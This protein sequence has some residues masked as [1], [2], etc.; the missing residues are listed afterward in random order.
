MTGASDEVWCGERCSVLCQLTADLPDRASCRV[1]IRCNCHA[2]PRTV[3]AVAVERRQVAARE[4]HVQGATLHRLAVE[5][6]KLPQRGVSGSGG[7]DHV[8]GLQS[9]R[10]T[11]GGGLQDD[12]P[13]VTRAVEF[14]REAVL[15]VDLQELSTILAGQVGQETLHAD[16][17]FGEAND[18]AADSH[19]TAGRSAAETGSG[20]TC[21]AQSGAQHAGP[22]GERIGLPE[23][24]FF[25]GPGSA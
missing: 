4:D 1:D 8:P 17:L 21:S 25:R 15:R 18:R 11:V 9:E 5:P 19:S 7:E 24:A 10:A 14:E 3:D 2:G 6:G 23:V 22:R 13:H 16:D 12:G 20:V